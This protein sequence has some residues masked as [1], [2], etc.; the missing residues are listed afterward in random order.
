MHDLIRGLAE[1]SGD[2]AMLRRD[3]SIEA[4]GRIENINEFISAAMDSAKRD[5]SLE[6]FLDHAALISDTD[7]LDSS[8]AVLL[9]TLHS[10]KGLE[11]PLV[12]M[13]G[14]EETLFP[15]SRSLPNGA[16]RG[17]ERRA[18]HAAWGS[19]PRTGTAA[20]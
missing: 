10:A 5:E 1:A 2:E 4:E 14:L 12:A 19:R 15:H 6:E 20:T 3:G 16:G 17:G 18:C 9:M 8:A 7:A 13:T 11:F